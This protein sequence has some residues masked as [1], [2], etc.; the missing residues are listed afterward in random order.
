MRA[1]D[2][3]LNMRFGSW[4]VQSLNHK[5]ERCNY[6]NCRCDC[7]NERVMRPDA[8]KRVSKLGYCNQCKRPNSMLNIED[9]PDETKTRVRQR[10]DGLFFHTMIADDCVT[11]GYTK[12][13]K[14]YLIDTDDAERVSHYSWGFKGRGYVTANVKCKERYLHNFLLENYES[15]VYVDH[16][17]LDKTDNRR[18]NLRICSLQENAFNQGM[19]KSNTSG[20]KGVSQVKQGKWKMRITFCQHDIHAEGFLSPYQAA[21]AYD[22][23]AKIL[24]GEFSWQ[25]H[26]HVDGVPANLDESYVPNVLNKLNRALSEIEW[27]DQRLLIR[28]R[29]RLNEFANNVNYDISTIHYDYR[30]RNGNGISGYKGVLH[31]QKREDFWC[32]HIAFNGKKL[33]AGAYD[34]LATA[35]AVYDFCVEILNGSDAWLNRDHKTDVGDLEVSLK[36]A[37]LDKIKHFL[38]EKVGTKNQER[39]K[40]AIKRLCQAELDFNCRVDSH[41]EFHNEPNY[42]RWDINAYSRQLV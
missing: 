17:N 29:E 16:V 41:S 33:Y 12:Y 26:G 15:S 11:Y 31:D 14:C 21:A 42:E 27:W 25:N 30:E 7:G 39:T 23:S 38:L 40:Q 32:V 2:D 24:F 20:M 8:L 36:I 6:W 28:A 22:L 35:A 13:G 4:I 10:E 34:T 5:S 3:L 19:P 9:L 37:L 18:C 1:F